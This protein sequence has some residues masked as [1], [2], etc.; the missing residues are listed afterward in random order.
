M[1]K[2]EQIEDVRKE[3]FHYITAI[4]K[5]QI[6]KLLKTGVIQM[7]LFDQ[8]L[9]EVEAF[10]GVR[11]VLRR[12]PIRAMEVARTRQD[13]LQSIQKEVDKQNLY[14]TEHRRANPE[15]ALGKVREKIERL[16]LSG[17]L[18]ATAVSREI[19]LKEDSDTLA[20]KAKL[21]GCYVL[22][23]DVDQQ[24]ASKETI[25][26]RYKDLE[27]VEWAFRTSKTVNLEVR[28][29]YVRTESHTRGHVFVVM[30]AYL[31]IAELARCWQG[32]N[33]TV[34][35]GIDQLATLCATQVLIKGKAHC[36][37]I[38]QPR[39]FLQQLLKAAQ[40][41]LPHVLASKGVNVTTKKKLSPRRKNR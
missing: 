37:Q 10:D 11:Y 4:T 32:L 8:D 18:S 2:S 3:G 19:L 27:L 26:N 14:Q 5:P 1:I 16:N 7:E 13:K 35:E 33:V 30:L 28:P 34:E 9:A 29:V 40:V 39:V 22:K 36:N 41:I 24:A 21:D 6:E 12:N 17:W 25:H 38:P 20:E 31:I 15:V 23:T